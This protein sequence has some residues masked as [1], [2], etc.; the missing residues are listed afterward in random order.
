MVGV[1][2]DLAQVGVVP[3]EV[4]PAEGHARGGD[5]ERAHGVPNADEPDARLA[6]FARPERD[7]L[8]VVRG[9]A[10]VAIQIVRPLDPRFVRRLQDAAFADQP[11]QAPRGVGA[12]AEAEDVDLVVRLVFLRE[13]PVS[14]PDVLREPVTECAA[15]DVVPARA[16]AGVVE[17]RLL[18]VVRAAR[19]DRLAHANDVG[20]AL[21]VVPGAVEADDKTTRFC[22]RH[23]HHSALSADG[24]S[25]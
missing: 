14:L 21:L 22:G 7:R 20:P 9:D 23:A 13:P 6:R 4:V 19:G 3:L 11:D 18:A 10:L 2:D 15:D 1:V 24:T 8:G 5:A 12:A 17:A 16:D 25:S